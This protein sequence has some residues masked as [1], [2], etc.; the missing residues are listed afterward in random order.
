MRR[1][2]SMVW[3]L[4]SAAAACCAALTVTLAHGGAPEPA[5]GALRWSAEE[6]A[7]LA[8]LSLQR[9]PPV[10]VDPSNTVERLPAAVELGRRLFNDAR[11]SRNGAVSCASC[12]DPAQQFQD[13]LPVSQGV[14]TGTRRA[15]PIVGAG[16]GP[17]LFWDGRKDSLWSQAL[18]PLEDAVEHGTNRTRVAHV[19]Q[20]HHRQRYEALF[21]AMPQLGGLPADAS[22]QGSAAEQVAWAAIEAR[23]RQDL[24][25]VFA[26]VGKA[27]AAYEKTL[28]HAP[29]RLDAYV[30]AV[31]RGDAAAGGLLRR[32][33]AR[34]LR[35]F[36]GK[37][38][39]VS[40]HNGPLMSDQQFH[41][42]GVPPR[43][44]ARPDRGRAAATAK[45]LGDEFNCLGP[46][47]DAR[48][49]QCQEL[50][51]MLSDDPA[52]E[53]AFKTPGLRGVAGRPPY[54]HAGQFATLEQ[55]V[56]HYVA[57]PHAAVGHSE[58][59]H[60]HA[61]AAA[62]THAERGPITLT[63]AEVA[64]LVRFF[65]TL[66]ADPKSNPNPGVAHERR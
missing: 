61:G 38:Q 10:P 15:M 3:M 44:V 24:S 54:M 4:G 21:G 33:E 55:V 12:H 45:V 8:S 48:P 6:K 34:G 37:A 62:G 7:V 52:L 27:I 13:G 35:L 63:D 30:E 1:W 23:R 39:C 20:G 9:L 42:T 41:N 43:D 5:A 28:Q 60:R 17:W 49:E 22:P 29:T 11:L 59:T 57:A 40:C 26:N 2:S 31:L 51:F 66:N 32:D 47:S 16:Y 36:I 65:D 58:L 25:R 46:F 19:V 53:G 64:D 18:G 50:R 14:G 56:R